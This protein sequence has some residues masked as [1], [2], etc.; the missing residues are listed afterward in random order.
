MIASPRIAPPR[1]APPGM[2]MPFTLG[3]LPAPTPEPM[4]VQILTHMDPLR[5]L[6]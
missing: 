4:L 6:P 5:T 3:Q 1:M 2:A